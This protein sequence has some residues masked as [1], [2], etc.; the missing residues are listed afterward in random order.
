MYKIAVIGDRDSVLG[1]MALGFAAR[2]VSDPGE[3]ASALH[4]LARTGDIGVIF[5]TEDIACQIEEDIAKY[6]LYT[7]EEFAHLMTKEQFEALNI[8]EIK[9]AIG[10]GLITYEEVLWLIETYT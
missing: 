1:Y 4:A 6:G 2:P 9:I 3:A 5:I 7:Y 10:K 8:A